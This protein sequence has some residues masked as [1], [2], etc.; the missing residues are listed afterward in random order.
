MQVTVTEVEVDATAV[1]GGVHSAARFALTAVGFGRYCPPSN[2]NVFA[3][4]FPEILSLFYT[5]RTEPEQKPGDTFHTQMLHLLSRSIYTSLP[6][7][8]TWRAI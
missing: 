2:R 4:S 3:P 6:I 1:G 5:A 8:L 7:S